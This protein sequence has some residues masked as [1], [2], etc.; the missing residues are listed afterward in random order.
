MCMFFFFF[1]FFFLFFILWVEGGGVVVMQ[2]FRIIKLIEERADDIARIYIYISITKA[3]RQNADPFK[4]IFIFKLGFTGLYRAIHYF[5][6]F[7][8]KT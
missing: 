5:S 4:P 8:S 7:Y 1:F 3:C 2:S 6:Y